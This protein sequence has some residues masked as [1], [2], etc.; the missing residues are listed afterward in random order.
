MTPTESR[1]VL[2]A[3]LSKG[4]IR[5]LSAGTVAPPSVFITQGQDWITPAQLASKRSIHWV[6]IC[7]VAAGSDAA[8]DEIEGLAFNVVESLK[9]VPRDWSLPTVH[10]A[11][12]ITLQGAQ[13]LAF[14][15]NI[16]GTI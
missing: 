5:V 3:A 16:R 12:T 9:S 13:Y 4:G 8:V 14:R 15:V 10:A 7:V 2:E 1:E 11:G 6:I